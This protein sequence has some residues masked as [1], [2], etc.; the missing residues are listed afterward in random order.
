MIMNQKRKKAE[1]LIYSVFDA[2]DQTHTNSDYYKKI[3]STMS[4]ED[5]EIFCRRRLPFRFHVQAFKVEPKMYEII[6]AF[7]VLGAPL[8][9]K[10]KMPYVYID[11]DT[12]EPVET[13]ECLVIY[14]HMKRMKQ[15]L[16]KK[17]HTSI[18]ID[19]RDMKTGLLTGD[20]KGGKETDREFESLATMGLEY[21]MDE[22]SRPKADAMEAMAQM[23]NAILTKGFVSDE[24]INVSKT[25]SIGKNLFNTYLIG[26]HI[27]SNLIDTDYMTPLTAKNK[28]QNIKR[29]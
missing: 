23:S 14:I 12:K 10:V 18:N 27:H 2:A 21:T 29:V 26:S 22:F 13:Q 28:K 19:K 16:T 5:F 24:D 15:M 1:E 4:D 20:D 25:D 6:K 11:P 8:L 17:N 9:E 3:F 7:K